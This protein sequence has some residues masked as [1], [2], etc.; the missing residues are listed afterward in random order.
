MRIRIKEAEKRGFLLW[1]PTVLL[2]NRLTLYIGVAYYNKN[3][4]KD[5]EPPFKASQL[6]P[7]VREIHRQKRIQGRKWVLVDV[8][9]SEGDKVK[10]SL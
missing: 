3:L 6:I 4:R 5:N 1:F 8:E 9:S 10:V 2:L 7:F